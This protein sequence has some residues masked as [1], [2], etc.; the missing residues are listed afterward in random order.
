MTLQGSTEGILI[1]KMLIC[2]THL[3]RGSSGIIVDSGRL[4]LC[5]KGLVLLTA[6][7]EGTVLQINRATE[8]LNVEDTRPS[9]V[10]GEGIR[11]KHGVS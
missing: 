6:G 11:L 10:Q 7:S 2:P 8:A 4:K 3:R 9:Q 1:R 5:L